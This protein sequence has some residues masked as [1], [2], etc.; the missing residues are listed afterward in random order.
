MTMNKKPLTQIK[1][2]KLVLKD[3][4]PYVKNPRF[5]RVGREF[6][7]FDLRPR[8]ALANWLLCVVGNFNTGTGNLTF[9]EDPSVGDGAIINKSTGK[10]MLTEH[11]FVPEPKVNDARSV[12]EHVIDAVKRKAKKGKVY[13]DGRHLVVFSEAI[14]KWYPNRV[15]R[16]LPGLHDFATVWAVGLD[17]SNDKE[18]VYGVAKFEDQKNSPAW[19]VWI[20]F[21]FDDWNVKRLQ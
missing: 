18:Y 1:D 11:V 20:S 13:A 6:T 3:M 14:G 5:L 9:S 7:N 21:D 10:F 19:H 17:H 12:E 15:G 8:E 2:L 16:Q 4:E